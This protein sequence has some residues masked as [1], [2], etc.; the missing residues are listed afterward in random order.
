MPQR[1]CLTVFA[2][3]MLSCEVSAQGGSTTGSGKF[4]S[5]NEPGQWQASKLMGLRIYNEANENIGQISDL[6]ISSSGEIKTVVI[7]TGGFLG[8][9]NR[10]IGVPF[11]EIKPPSDGEKNN[12][13]EVAK[14]SKTAEDSEKASPPPKKSSEKDVG[15][16]VFGILRMS[17][18]ELKTAPD[19]KHVQ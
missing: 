4:I 8:M 13:L 16:P 3:L 9:G 5:Q 7:S 18:E 12:R 17:N 14:S 2:L 11:G 15:T 19:F 1:F 6:I 10:N